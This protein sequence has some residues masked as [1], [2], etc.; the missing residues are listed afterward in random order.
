MKRFESALTKSKDE[1]TKHN[2]LLQRKEGELTSMNEKYIDNQKILEKYELQ[3]SEKI[4][5]LAK[6]KEEMSDQKVQP[7]PN[8]L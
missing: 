5:S 4:N 1:N 6:L 7:T 8:I 3:L 2:L